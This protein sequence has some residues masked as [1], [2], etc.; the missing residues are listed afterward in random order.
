MCVMQY[1]AM[2]TMY[3]VND[4][5][6]NSILILL[7]V[8]ANDIYSIFYTILFWY[9]LLFLIYFCLLMIFYSINTMCSN[10]SLIFNKWLTDISTN[11]CQCLNAMCLSNTSKYNG[12]DIILFLNIN[13]I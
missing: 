1:N 7:N 4:I 9:C 6:P 8:N 13:V 5:V 10:V 3:C 12:N 11:V 2:Q